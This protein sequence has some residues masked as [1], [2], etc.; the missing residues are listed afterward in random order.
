VSDKIEIREM[1]LADLERV[2]EIETASFQSPWSLY[3]FEY[4]IMHNEHANYF[5]LVLN[6]V[7]IGYVGLWAFETVGHIVNMA[8][9]S[10]HRRKGYAR[11]LLDYVLLYGREIGVERF[12]LEVRVGNEA[13]INLYRSKGFV[14]VGVRPRYY[15]DNREDALIM[16]TPGEDGEI[17]Y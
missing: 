17:K 1:T 3:A 8:I 14:D 9:D 5:V 10:N 15:Q 11:Q 13:A 12:T 6:D 16:W 2:M 7:I 4:D